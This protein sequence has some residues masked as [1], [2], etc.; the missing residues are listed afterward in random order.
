MLRTVDF[1]NDKRVL[2]AL[3][4]AA[5]V[6]V[7]LSFLEKNPQHNPWA[8]LDLRDPPGWAT[9]SKL[10]FLRD[11]PTQCRNVLADS[12]VTFTALPPAGQDACER[13]DRLQLTDFPFAGRVPVT[14]CPVAAAMHLWFDRSVQPRSKQFLGQEV[15]RIRHYGAYNCRRLYGRKEGGWSEHATG[16]AI[17]IS[18]FEMRDGA[19]VTVLEDW[20][21]SDDNAQFLKAIRD[22]ACDIFGTVLSPD[23]NS[24]HSDHFH[25]DQ[26]PRSF[27]A[28]R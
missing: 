17:D 26:A 21:G 10:T 4:I 25:F 19:I 9:T 2:E 23:Y 13:P 27:G 1:T 8:P 5:L 12:D 16:N 28:C 14:T 20:S 18:G 6:L 11:N 22:D 15:S 7:G 24:A 3:F